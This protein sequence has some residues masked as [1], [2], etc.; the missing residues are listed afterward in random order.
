MAVRTAYA[1]AAVSGEVLT[2]ANVNRLPGGWIGYNEVTANQ[3]GITAEVD[4][5]GITV[6]PTV[7]SSRRIRVTV[8]LSLASSVANDVAT[9]NIKEGA[10]YLQVRE[11]H[12]PVGGA[13]A[14]ITA[15]VVLT[16][17]SGAHAYKASL[18]RA[19]GTGTIN[20]AASAARPAFIVVDDLGPAS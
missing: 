3:T 20:T 16:P 15:S 14:M 11:V 8:E 6:S 5:T 13:T 1:G 4:L 7:G 9:L 10:T 12:L 17:T 2:A 19:A 18:A